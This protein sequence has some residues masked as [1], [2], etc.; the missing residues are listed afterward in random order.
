[1]SN[2]IN[3]D[4]DAAVVGGIH[5]DS[6]NVTNNVTTNNSTVT[7]NTQNIV[8]QA[9]K[10]AE[11][12]K[13]SNEEIFLQSVCKFFDDGIL[14][15]REMAELNRL[16]LQLQI[17]EQRANTIIEQVRRDALV[18]NSGQSNDFLSAQL[19]EEIYEAVAR[20]NTEVLKRKFTALEKIAKDNMDSDVQFYHHMLMS[21]LFPEKSTM[22]F[23]NTST[24]NYWQLFWTH[25]AYVKLGNS[26]TAEALMPR[27][28]AFGAPAGDISLLM[29]VDN[30][31]DYIHNGKD[32]Y[33]HE[34]TL[35]HLAKAAEAGMS[36]V[37]YPL[38][39]A[40]EDT[41]N[42]TKSVGE[43]KEFFA[44]QTLREFTSKPQQKS[45]HGGGTK[46]SPPA[47][48]KFNP[49]NVQL[50]QMQGF[51]PL[52]AAKQMGLGN[53]G[54]MAQMSGM[55]NAWQQPVN[56]F[57]GQPYDK[58]FNTQPQAYGQSGQNMSQGFGVMPATMPGINAKANMQ[59]PPPMPGA[60]G[61][62][63]QF[64]PDK[65][66]IPQKSQ[67]PD[68][69]N[70]HYGII[71]T[72]SI[73]LAN[74]YRVEH[75]VIIEI[76]TNF[77][78]ESEERNMHWA[79]L[80]LADYQGSNFGSWENVN[81]LLSDFISEYS[82]PAGPNLHLMIV[83]GADVIPVPEI[84]DPYN[85][86]QMLPTDMCYCFEGTCLAD[87]VEDRNFELN[88]RNARNNVARLPL[89]DGYMQTDPVSDLGAYFNLSSA[90]AGGIDVDS[91]VMASNNKWIP[92]SATMSQ[93]L[94]LLCCDNEPSLT[95]DRMYI[96]PSLLTEDSESTS[97][98]ID[99]ISQ[100]G[101]LMFN[102]H[103]SDS[104]QYSGFYSSGEAFNIDMLKKSSARVFNTV[105][106]FGARYKGGYKREQSMVL[107][108]LYGGGV[109]LYTGSLIPVPMYSNYDNDEVR[110]L[111]LNPGTGSEVFMRLYPLYQFKGMTAGRALLQAKCD[112]FNMMR[113]VE[114]DDFSLSTAMMFCLY[115]NPMLHVKPRPDV[116]E[117]ARSNTSIPA[118]EVKSAPHP[119]MLKMKQRVME[120]H[121]E[122]SL[123]D[124]ARGYV[125]QNFA[126]IRSM[127]EQ[128]VYQALG[129][130]PAY[131]ESIDAFSQPLSNGDYQTGYSFN[132]YDPNAMFSAEKR[133]ETD[134]NGKIKRVYYT[135]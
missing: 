105:A 64:V 2:G 47:M 117:A 34:R 23:I 32:S 25:I 108:A 7:N 20:N 35:S 17:T 58:G 82:L 61:M 15:Q 1:M 8:H 71:L 41:A 74:K 120:K 31:W 16:R 27:L 5:T 85:Q 3:L 96:S 46:M 73:V 109:L 53:N 115:G 91:V 24:D 52:A 112:Y 125:D 77:Y 60:S 94:P 102:L 6:H 135:K 26:Q 63:K 118:G 133:V 88:T 72:N 39:Y 132:Y 11:E 83:G 106:C 44:T 28:G 81:S 97:K 128:Y 107:N 93:H 36:E 78:N 80:D 38:W 116:V 42:G 101:M 13:Q 18:L 113:H 92:A 55:Q 29:A 76:F 84:T 70:D 43:F 110:E 124:Q 104:P 22:V 114:H 57:G 62:S 75:E 129:L 69:F 56:N 127:T 40:V 9:Q 123:L 79:F 37:L 21:S 100:T 12:I 90:F 99:S 45:I 67:A 48:P 119:V 122:K 10:T 131:L 66:P 130:P 14:D 121:Q 50:S 89:E 54:G 59:A 68:E 95:R 98:Y 49:Q 4:G 51:N 103:G 86:S 19:L 87:Y 111:M 30:L 126:A 134:C 65:R 33:Y